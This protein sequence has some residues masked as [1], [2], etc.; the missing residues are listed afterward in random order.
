MEPWITLMVT[1][2][3]GVVDVSMSKAEA[4]RLAATILVRLDQEG[5]E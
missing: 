3:E 4:I 5:T 2:D 1:S